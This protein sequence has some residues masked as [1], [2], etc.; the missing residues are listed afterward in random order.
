[1][2]NYTRTKNL[3][4]NPTSIG[5]SLW[6]NTSDIN[7]SSSEINCGKLG[8]AD[9][10]AGDVVNIAVSLFGSLG[11]I[12]VILV[13]WRT[14][15]LRTICGFL[16]SNLAIADLLTTAF[17]NVPFSLGYTAERSACK[18][19]VSFRVALVIVHISGAI[20]LSTLTFLSI[21]RCFAI[22]SPLRH[23][24]FTT[25]TKLKVVLIKIWID[26]LV[27][28]ILQELYPNIPLLWYAPT[29]ALLL[30][31]VIIL[32]CGVLTILNVRKM[33]FRIMDLHQN[34]DGGSSG[35]R[36]RQRNKQVAKTTA[37]VITLFTF[38]WTPFTVMRLMKRS[39][40]YYSLEYWFVTLGLANSAVNPCIYFYRHRNYRQAL[41][42]IFRR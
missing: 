11:N 30:C 41:K 19:P 24:T 8:T 1:M 32:T 23:R 18:D 31:F 3:E 22:C 7:K 39:T 36:M 15:N 40:A 26:S 16:I 20:S 13:I 29:C 37:L 35:G 10:I 2:E 34:H 4:S 33:S 14:P 12:L 28:P 9:K 5:F 6:L 42:T 17:V 38:S 25:F 21:D 27:F